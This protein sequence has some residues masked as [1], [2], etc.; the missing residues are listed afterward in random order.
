MTPS[1]PIPF[2][3]ESAVGAASFGVTFAITAGLLLLVAAVLI[4]ARRKG[5]V[6]TSPRAI[7]SA[8]GEAL[9]HVASKRLSPAVTVHTVQHGGRGYMIVEA[10]RGTQV[11]VE[12]LAAPSSDMGSAT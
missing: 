6:A 3:T 12:P 11:S 7:S 2:R 4:V 10:A 5:W 1:A 8:P 9:V